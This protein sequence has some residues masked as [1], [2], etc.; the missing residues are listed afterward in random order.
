[1]ETTS[2]QPIFPF[3]RIALGWQATENWDGTSDKNSHPRWSELREAKAQQ[4]EL[5]C[6]GLTYHMVQ[7]IH[8]FFCFCVS[9]MLS[10]EG[11]GTVIVIHI[12][13][14]DTKR[15]TLGIDLLPRIAR[16][17]ILLLAER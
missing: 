3:A 9:E 2:E 5:H 1:M 12:L 7:F 11:T 17:N 10:F 14:S 8:C 13:P 16:R 15:P 6:R 4:A